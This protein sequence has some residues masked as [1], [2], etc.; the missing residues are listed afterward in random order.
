MLENKDEDDSPLDTVSSS[1]IGSPQSRAAA[2]AAA[3]ASGAPI[4][5]TQYITGT[6]DEE[7]GVLSNPRCLSKTAEVNGKTLNRAE[8]ETDDDFDSDASQLAGCLNQISSRSW[9]TQS[10]DRSGSSSTTRNFAS[11]TL[12]VAP[13]GPSSRTF[14]AGQSSFAGFVERRGR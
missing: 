5:V 6:R 9:E 10:N 14:E 1:P 13:R 8:T 2:R 11:A 3:G 4:F 7:D 12:S